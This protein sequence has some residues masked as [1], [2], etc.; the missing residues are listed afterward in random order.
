[1]EQPSAQNWREQEVVQLQNEV[2]LL[3]RL[4]GAI[5]PI[6]TGQHAHHGRGEGPP[7]VSRPT[8]GASRATSGAHGPACA[9]QERTAARGA[10]AA[11]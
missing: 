10:S 9:L 3:I 2:A 6:E 8:P 11:W 1:M 5:T 4:L 7:A